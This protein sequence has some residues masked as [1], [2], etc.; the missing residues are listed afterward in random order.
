MDGWQVHC[1]GSTVEDMTVPP[2][3]PV[4]HAHHW[5][6][7]LAVAIGVFTAMAMGAFAAMQKRRDDGS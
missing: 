3:A 7:W 5:A 1:C 2:I 4:A 6:A